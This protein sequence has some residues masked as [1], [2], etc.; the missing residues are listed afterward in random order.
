MMKYFL[1]LFLAIFMLASCSE[2]QKEVFSKP[3]I[4]FILADD[5][6]YNELGCYG[7]EIIRTPNI[8]GLAA[9]G[10]RFTQHYSGSPVCAPSRS[11][12][13]TGLHTGHTYTRDNREIKPE[14]Q[15][16]I[17][18][19]ALTI[20][21]VLKQQG[22]TTAAMGKWG[23]GFPGSEGDP[24]NQGFDLFFGYNCQRHAHNHYPRYL[25]RNDEKIMLEGN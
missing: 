16:P 2:H 5:L 4:I 25:W 14:G 13:L 10:M 19:S 22:Y 23:L 21:E 8:D 12:L 7:Q 18:D 24:N 9:E 6:G 3:N 1:F 17:P 20:A 11:V 15:L